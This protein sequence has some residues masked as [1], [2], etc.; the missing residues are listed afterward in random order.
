MTDKQL[1]I[2]SQSITGERIKK[3][4]KLG[5]DTVSSF[6]DMIIHMTYYSY[7]TKCDAVKVFQRKPSNEEREEVEEIVNKDKNY[8]GLLSDEYAILDKV[9]Y[10]DDEHYWYHI[11]QTWF[12]GMSESPSHKTCNILNEKCYENDR[13]YFTHYKKFDGVFNMLFDMKIY[14]MNRL[15]DF[16]YELANR[17]K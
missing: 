16:Y 2:L 14:S 9:L 6:I 8:Y 10:L 13:P 11:K 15:I 12:K 1:K 7:G 3:L 4:D 5:F 17:N